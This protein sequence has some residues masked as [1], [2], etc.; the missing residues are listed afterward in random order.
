[1]KRFF[2]FSI[3]IYGFLN[4]FAL[5]NH[6]TEIHT[7]SIKDKS[8]F[9]KIDSV[10]NQ[11]AQSKQYNTFNITFFPQTFND[12][13][14]HDYEDYLFPKNTSK[15]MNLNVDSIF[16]EI[17]PHMYSFKTALYTTFNG[18]NY[19]LTPNADKKF[20]N[21][22]K[23]LKTIKLYQPLPG[24]QPHWLIQYK[25]D[26]S[27]TLKSFTIDTDFY[28]TDYLYRDIYNSYEE[29]NI[30]KHTGTNHTDIHDFIIAS[31]EAKYPIKLSYWEECTREGNTISQ[32]FHIC[33]LPYSQNKYINHE[34]EIPHN[35]TLLKNTY[36]KHKVICN[37]WSQSIDKRE[38]INS[39]TIREYNNKY[40]LRIEY[41]II[42]QKMITI[43]FSLSS[44]NI[45]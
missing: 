22:N 4:C 43:P 18:K 28:I 29:I 36:I 27:L 16:I 12:F 44:I 10:L 42:P 8:F 24:K 33:K 31:K 14:K 23:N 17:S 38:L 37:N 39:K 5:L 41:Y 11:Y 19:I 7:A 32:K 20:I 1:M 13:L 45:Y 15:H 21:K 40:I 26:G 35:D 9:Q 2:I 30:N 3:Y 25:K 6:K 34:D